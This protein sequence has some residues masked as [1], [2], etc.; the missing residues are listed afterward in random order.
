MILC[1]MRRLVSRYAGENYAPEQPYLPE[2][3]GR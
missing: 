1:Y 2:N 3:P